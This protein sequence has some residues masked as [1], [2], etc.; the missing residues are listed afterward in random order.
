MIPPTARPCKNRIRLSV[1][2]AIIEP[3]I[4]RAVAAYGKLDDIAVLLN[5]VRPME[6]KREL[7]SREAQN[8][9]RHLN[10]DFILSNI[11]EPLSMP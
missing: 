4:W 6:I 5:I 1:F 11:L 7:L 2:E 10:F 8:R 9:A 3:A